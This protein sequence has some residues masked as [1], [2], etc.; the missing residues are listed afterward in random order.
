[1]HRLIMG[2][3]DRKLVV[4]HIDGD[5]L[6]NRR[7]NLR[8]ATRQQNGWNRRGVERHNLRGAYLNKSGRWEAHIKADGRLLYLGSFDTEQEAHAAYLAK[9]A[10]L[11]GDWNPLVAAIAKTTAVA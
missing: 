1:M 8:I 11:H 4:D 7:S 10:E 5:T 9:A 6:N 3:E 2:L